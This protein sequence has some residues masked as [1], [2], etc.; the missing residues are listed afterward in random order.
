MTFATTGTALLVSPVSKD[1][2][3]HEL[4]R[5]HPK[6]LRV[7]CLPNILKPQRPNPFY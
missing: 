4:K 5:L 3:V 1:C 7:S 6:G 2:V